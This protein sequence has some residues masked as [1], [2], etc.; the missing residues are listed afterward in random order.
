MERWEERCLNSIETSVKDIRESEN[1]K[2]E[3]ITN[4][5]GIIIAAEKILTEYE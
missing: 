5:K 3:I 4:L 1:D 2:T